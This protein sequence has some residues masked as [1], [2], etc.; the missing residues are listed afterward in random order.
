M[1]CTWILPLGGNT[2]NPRQKPHN[3]A[4]TFSAKEQGGLLGGVLTGSAERPWRCEEVYGGL[5]R[6]LERVVVEVLESP[7]RPLQAPGG[8]LRQ[9]V[10]LVF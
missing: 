4:F 7:W 10:M 3:V 5:L 2:P 1:Q 9:R 8:R 6:V